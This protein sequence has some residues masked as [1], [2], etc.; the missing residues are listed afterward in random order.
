M[1]LAN[2][3]RLGRYEIR[4][5][6]GAG[7]MGEVY[8]ARDP[9]INRDVAIKVLPASFSSDGDRLR[10]F[11]Q[12][13]EA[14]GKLN[15]PNILAVYDVETHDGSPYVVYE[16][17]E[18]ETLRERLSG[19]A[20]STRKA[21]DY[22]A[23]IAQGLTAAHAKGI[24]HRDLKPENIF[25]TN[26]GRIKILDF[27]LAKLIEPTQI[28]EAQTELLTR[29]ANTDPG[30]V[31]GTV[32][33]MSPEQ[34]RAQR[35]DHRS[36]IFSLGL[37]LY[38]MLSGKR[39]FR[40][41]S[42]VETLNAILK[43]D[44]AELSESNSQINPALERVVMHCLEKSP[45]QRF[46][47]ARDV[48][49]ALE[50]LSGLSSSRTVAEAF[51]L[52]APRSKNRERLAWIVA[53]TCLLVLLAAL[54]FAVSYLRRAP[55]DE[56]VL[57]LS[58]LPPEKATMSDGIVTSFAISPDGRRLAF[59][60]SSDGQN[61][62]WV[63]SL[64]SLTAQALPGTEG[65]SSASA[66]FWSPDSRFIGFGAGGKLKKIEV[67][68]APPQTL[69]DA[70]TM[71]GGT[72]NRNGVILFATGLSS[73]LYRVPATGGEPTPV[74]TLDQSRS[75]TLHRWPY[76]LPDGQRFLYFVRSREA[77]SEIF[78]GSLDGKET[79]R[80]LPGAVAAVY[81]A[82]GFVL[83][84]RD[85]IL[86]AQRFDAGELQLT[87]EPFPIAE[88]VAFNVGLG[89]G[90]FS[91]SDSGVLAYAAGSSE[92]NQP[93]WF[94]RAGKQLGS[95]GTAGLYFSVWLSP[96]EN[97][98]AVNRVDTQTGTNDV[99]LFDLQRGVPSRFTTDPASDSNP[100]WSPDGGEIVF[101]SNREGIN[102][103]YRKIASG[104]GT[105]ELLFKSDEEKWPDD[106]SLDG[107]FIVYQSFN[108]K[109]KWDLWV[110]PM[111]G[112]RQP[113]KFLQTEFNEQQAQFSPD[114]KWLAYVSDESGAQEVYVRTF[115]DS[116]G[117][118][119]V[120]T[121]GGNQPAWRRDGSELFYI[122]ADRQLMS[123]DFRLGAA[124]EASV[125]KG[126]FVTR[127]IALADFRNQYEPTADGQRFLINSTLES[128]EAAPISVVVNWM[129]DLKK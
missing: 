16:L 57:R 119:R 60:A 3:T 68:G 11:E 122:A 20:L 25:I 35:V 111:T 114:G 96:D 110:L 31:M 40:G 30:S 62:L 44:P 14:T 102:N 2:G 98:A 128:A 76:F 39:P 86:M 36:D 83:F 12:E 27:G 17:L 95:V 45:E 1:T 28:T 46:Q 87:G 91:V 29:K 9:K 23:Q 63:R 127:V 70:S 78:M 54:P 109:T 56:R 92:I 50:A 51:P 72:W 18:G 75:E 116:G 24:I 89:R 61:R 94:D 124:F 103:L 41:D 77:E 115:P 34:V 101:N 71:R 74:T 7:G 21:L 13:V 90:A 43:E 84:L 97:R 6:L 53:G 52:A 108:Q 19:G 59:V 69:C 93:L 129:A 55:A 104:G 32:G 48:T 88:R 49:F 47:S 79:K 118:W 107:R 117:K 26:D 37:I 125:P 123:V 42:A 33:Y 67:S 22:A 85:G 4:S 106:W 73:V 82:P 8:L 81:A 58:L 65:A 15:H 66:P 100:T 121:G 5:Q 120:S 112:D 113:T 99:W 80:L 10:R 105:E 126:L 38:E 64:D